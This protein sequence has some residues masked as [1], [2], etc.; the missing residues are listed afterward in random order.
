LQCSQIGFTLL[1]TFT[2]H[3]G[4]CAPMESPAPTDAGRQDSPWFITR[5]ASAGDGPSIPRTREAKVAGG[6]AN[7]SCRAAPAAPVGIDDALSGADDAPPPN[8]A[9]LETYSDS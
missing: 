4:A 9:R 7:G 1:R 3:L 6:S 2:G 8:W 5:D